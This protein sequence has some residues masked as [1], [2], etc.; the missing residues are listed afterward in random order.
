[1]LHVSPFLDESQRYHLVIA[2]T[3]D[4]SSS[5]DLSIDVLDADS[6]LPVV[7]T[8]LS[9]DRR[10]AERSALR[11]ALL[12]P[13]PTHRVSAGI[14]LHAFRL[15]RKGASFVAHPSKRTVGS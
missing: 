13:L 4:E 5:I 3:N 1:V 7:R 6:G 15:W 11:A 2:A 9:V 14:H 10:R 8:M 12:T